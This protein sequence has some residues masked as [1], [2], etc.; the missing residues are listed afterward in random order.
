MV[1]T[2]NAISDPAQLTLLARLT[3]L[4][5]DPVLVALRDPNDVAVAGT[6]LRALCTYGRRAVQT[7]AATRVLLGEIGARGRLPVTLAGGRLV[8]TGGRGQG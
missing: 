6:T 3:A 8:V 1:G 4:G 5:V 2:V 7:E